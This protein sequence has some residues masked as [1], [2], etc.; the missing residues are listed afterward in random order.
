MLAVSTASWGVI[1]GAVAALAAA[2]GFVFAGVQLSATR[3]ATFSQFLLDLDD[4][5]Y[6]YWD[7]H[8]AL[9]RDGKWT[10]GRGPVSNEELASVEGYMGLFERLYV[11][12]NNGTVKKDY[13]EHF[14]KYRLI[15]LWRTP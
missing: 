3:R 13:V 4:H 8:V 10:Q 1:V 12:L 7:V 11:L 2:V 6:R 14:Y 5:F 15:N 9:M